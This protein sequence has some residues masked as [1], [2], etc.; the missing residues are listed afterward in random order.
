[1]NR[2][3]LAA[4]LLGCAVVAQANVPPVISG[5][6]A[7]TIE[8]GAR[9]A[10]VPT[11]VDADGPSRKFV[12]KNRPAW[13]AFSYQTGGVSGVAPAPGVWKDIQI[14]VDDGP[15]TARSLPRFTITVTKPIN[16]PPV[17][18]GQPVTQL[19]VTR[20]WTFQ[21]SASDP[22]SEPL[23]FTVANKPSWATF[24]PATGK[25][26]GTP[27][28]GAVGTYSNIVVAVTDGTTS[29]ALPMFALVVQSLPVEAATL[30]WTPPTKNVDGTALTNLAGY[31]IYY[32]AS[33]TTLGQVVEI[34]NAG[35]SAYVVENLTPG[36]WY[37]AVTAFN[38]DG[39][40]SAMS[41]IASKTTG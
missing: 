14:F 16:P 6:P 9:Y 29:V 27:G 38:A 12:I 31:R 10:F 41:N 21:P 1:M 11:V 13:L 22:K 26:S 25:L 23:T 39:K 20:P 35:V 37:F 2:V 40:E 18:S 33:S 19:T 28:A 36:T 3:L 34:R 24:D 32:G 30:S 4:L 17:I 15:N 7:T 8:Q 5:T